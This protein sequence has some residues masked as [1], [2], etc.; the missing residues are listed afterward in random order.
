MDRQL[1]AVVGASPRNFWTTC[2][3]HNLTT[4]NPDL[5]VVPVTPNHAEIQGLPTVP[6]VS[7]LPDTPRAAIIAIRREAAVEAVRTLTAAGTRDIVCVT[8]GFVERGDDTGARLQQELIDIVSGTQTRLW[9][10]NCVGF[11]DFA[12]KICAVAEPVWLGSEPGPV[13]I[14]SQSGAL[15]SA[16]VAAAAQ[17]RL[18][19]D[20]CVSTGNGAVNAVPEALQIAL[21]RDTTQVVCAYIEGVR[22]DQVD[23]LTAAFRMAQELGKQVIVLKSGVSERGQKAVMSHTASI[24]GTDSVFSELLREH[25]V[26]R[27]DGVDELVRLATLVLLGVKE[28]R[29]RAVSVL[30]GSGGAAALS[31]DLSER[32][33]VRLTTFAASTIERIRALAGP[34]SLIDNPLD[35]IG[36]KRRE[37]DDSVNGWV[38]SD[39]NTG[40]VLMPWSVQFPSETVHESVHTWNWGDLARLSTEHEMPLIITSM[41][42]VPDTDFTRTYRERHPHVAVLDNLHLTF[43]ALGKLF[44]APSREPSSAHAAA[45]EAGVLSE[46]DS[47]ELVATAGVPL[48]GGAR[49]ARG[50]DPLVATAG[51]NPPFAVKVIAPVSHKARIGGVLLGVPSQDALPAAIGQ[52]TENVVCAGLSADQ[53]EGCLVEEMVFGREILI[54]LN[55]DPVL[56]RY[57]VVGLGGSA[58]EIAARSTTRRLPLAHG[59]AQRLLAAV[60]VVDHPK[61]VSVVE[62]VCEA[63]TREHF[64]KY[65]TVEINPLIVGAH[66]CWAADAV[67]TVGP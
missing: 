7:A 57:V 66:D 28:G 16:F 44:P 51:L 8:D 11:A 38:F 63:F 10:P 54:G 36:V 1:V 53:V 58:T 9:G 55:T 20:F 4:L 40:L 29:D 13:S 42:P 61:A 23:R 24:A 32:Y 33:G 18:G 62:S 21:G 50:E 35:V 12:E 34:G 27:A 5:Q 43:A 30:G 2:A 14:V 41:A 60:G 31:S 37:G 19:L 39:P 47:R 59:E 56:G 45:P 46:A 15:L 48:V 22:G 3:I 65:Q 26:L 6:D 17:E 64:E 49:V 67:V 52:I 25:G